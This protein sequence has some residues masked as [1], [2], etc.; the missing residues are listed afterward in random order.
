M[1]IRDGDG[2]GGVGG[3]RVKSRPRAPTRK[4]EE[5]VN[6]R[7]NNGSVK[8]RR[9]P[10]GIAQQPVYYA[11]AVSTAVLA[12]AESQGQCPLHRCGVTT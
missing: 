9:C 8:L 12:R 6:R 5:A 11:I 4:T 2:D 10:L 1:L 3:E 7:Q